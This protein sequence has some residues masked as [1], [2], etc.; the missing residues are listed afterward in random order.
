M[1]RGWR[2]RQAHCYSLMGADGGQ[3]GHFPSAREWTERVI[4]HG[5]G[6]PRSDETPPPAGGVQRIDCGPP[7]A[8]W[9]PPA[10]QGNDQEGHFDSQEVFWTMQVLIAE[11]DATSRITLQTVLT[12]WGY[13]VRVSLDGDEAFAALQ[14]EDAP[15][16]AL[17]DWEMPGMD[18]PEVCRRIRMQERARPPYLILLT[19]RDEVD[20]IVQGLE[21]G[22]DDYISKPFV[23]AELKARLDV[24]RRMI[25]YQNES[26]ERQKLQGVLEMAGAV[27]H[28]LNQPLQ[29]II[30]SSELLLLGDP[31]T[32]EENYESLQAIKEGVDRLRV[33]T[34]KIWNITRYR[35]RPYLKGQIIDIEEATE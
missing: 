5:S 15:P 33:L 3:S 11:D 18:G 29:S 10:I 31:E 12:R 26:E 30:A 17:L 1:K 9:G 16:L 13:H 32:S 4:G 25:S 35:S 22:A 19:A 7:M 6:T 28:E 23:N 8:P 27:C 20:D 21:A 24:G 34:R 2:V 14:K